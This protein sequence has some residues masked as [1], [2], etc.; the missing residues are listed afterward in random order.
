[1]LISLERNDLRTLLF[2][3]LLENI[4]TRK[5]GK[6]LLPYEIPIEFL[7]TELEIYISSSIIVS[8]VVET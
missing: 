8:F 4:F 7:S 2:S 3:P 5:T 1:M 6:F